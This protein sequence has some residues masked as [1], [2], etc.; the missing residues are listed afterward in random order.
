MHRA[1]FC[2][3]G[4][5]LGSGYLYCHQVILNSD[6]FSY[7]FSL[8]LVS[9]HLFW[10]VPISYNIPCLMF[11]K[12]SLSTFGFQ[13]HLSTLFTPLF[14]LKMCQKWIFITNM[15]DEG[16]IIYGRTS[17]KVLPRT[18][19]SLQLKLL[20]YPCLIAWCPISADITLF[21]DAIG[22][23]GGLGTSEL[24]V[25]QRNCTLTISVLMEVA[26]TS[27]FSWIYY[28]SVTSLS[29]S[30]SYV[31]TSWNMTTDVTSKTICREVV[32]M[33][34]WSE[35]WDWFTLTMYKT[36]QLTR[37]LCINWKRFWRSA[38]SVVSTKPQRWL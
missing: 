1:R 24:M 16:L 19:H 12:I 21:S 27:L 18:N 30:S 26:T 17:G 20:N 7:T 38:P 11:C 34:L 13:S 4:F 5:R 25:G 2:D 10:D 31:T 6:H 14:P 36:G 3:L 37:W 33:L 28:L 35:T 22:E 15:W 23:K 8:Y 32:S 29:F 9:R